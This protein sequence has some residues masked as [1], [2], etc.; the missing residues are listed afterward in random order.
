MKKLLLL[1]LLSSFISTSFAQSVHLGIRAGLNESRL[2]DD[3]TLTDNEGND[4]KASTSYISRFHA[5]L[6]AEIA[7]GKFSIQPGVFYT[8]KGGQTKYHKTTASSSQSYEDKTT[9][10][11][12]EIPVNILYNIPVSMGKIFVGGGPYAA[13]GFSGHYNSAYSSVQGMNMIAGKAESDLRFGENGLR[14]P[15]YGINTLLGLRLKNNISFNVGYGFGLANLYK[16][17]G[18]SAKN[19]VLSIS[20]GYEFL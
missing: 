19:K 20:V 12:L 3:I 4:V 5:G 10:N 6:F 11:Y 9:L 1:L 13:F 7:V 17:V 14:N 18:S 16:A 2:S 15:D 8:Q